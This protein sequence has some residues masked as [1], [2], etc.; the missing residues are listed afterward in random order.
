MVTVFE[1]HDFLSCESL[2]VE[3]HVFCDQRGHAWRVLKCSDWFT[4][5]RVVAAMRSGGR[6]QSPLFLIFFGPSLR[7]PHCVQSE[8]GCSSPAYLT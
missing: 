7:V 6:S 2:V 1:V 4:R 5:P 3:S 8:P